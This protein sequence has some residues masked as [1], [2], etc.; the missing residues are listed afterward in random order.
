V[1]FLVRSRR[2]RDLY[3]LARDLENAGNLCRI[4]RGGRAGRLLTLKRDSL[5]SGSN[6]KRSFMYTSPSPL[7]FG[8]LQPRFMLLRGFTIRARVRVR[9]NRPDDFDYPPAPAVISHW[10]LATCI[11]FFV[12]SVPTGP[13]MRLARHERTARDVYAW[14]SAR[15]SRDHSSCQT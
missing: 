12:S 2:K 1:P 7:L 4:F 6:N 9:P 8:A 15:L 13:S 14:N 5:Q 11:R 3:D 10:I